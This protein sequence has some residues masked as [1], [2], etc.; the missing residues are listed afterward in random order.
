MCLEASKN[1]FWVIFAVELPDA[2]SRYAIYFSKVVWWLTELKSQQDG[3]ESVRN[4]FLHWQI[5]EVATGSKLNGIIRETVVSRVLSLKLI[6][7]PKNAGRRAACESCAEGLFLK[8]NRS[9]SLFPQRSAFCFCLY[10]F[11]LSIF[12][13]RRI[14][15]EMYCIL[16]ANQLRRIFIN[17]K[18]TPMY[19][20]LAWFKG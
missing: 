10:V 12:I 18:C 8:K 5:C 17:H 6:S 15:I 11:P 9:T 20:C 3:C 4:S 1:L 19:K 13:F 14:T 7:F 2:A 16:G